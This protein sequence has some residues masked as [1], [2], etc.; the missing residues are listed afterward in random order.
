[1]QTDKKNAFEILTES[2]QTNG[3]GSCGGGLPTTYDVNINP[4]NTLL[5]TYNGTFTHYS[6]KLDPVKLQITKNPNNGYFNAGTCASLY[7][8]YDLILIKD[9]PK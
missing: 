6:F 5:F 3:G 1:M 2:H 9:Q 7:S 8:N 4:D